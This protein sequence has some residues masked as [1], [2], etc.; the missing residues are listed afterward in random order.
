V[1]LYSDRNVVDD[2][3]SLYPGR[4]YDIY[5]TNYVNGM[6]KDFDGTTACLSASI[7]GLTSTTRGRPLYVV[8]DNPAVSRIS[9]GVYKASG[10]ALPASALIFNTSTGSLLWT[11]W[12]VTGTRSAYIAP[13]YQQLQLLTPGS[14]SRDND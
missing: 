10:T 1:S 13:I 12:R 2:S 3:D 6:R 7:V 9:Q 5:F 4:P 8:V 14:S 11:H